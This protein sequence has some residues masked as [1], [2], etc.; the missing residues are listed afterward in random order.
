MTLAARAV[1]AV[2]QILDVEQGLGHRRR[3]VRIGVLA[4]ARG[5]LPAHIGER[6]AFRPVALQRP[7]GDR[8][9]HLQQ[10][11]GEHQRGRSKCMP[12]IARRRAR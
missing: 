6:L 10:A 9:Q 11:A 7:R 3:R 2:Q 8:E 5:K 1:R 12:R 4:R